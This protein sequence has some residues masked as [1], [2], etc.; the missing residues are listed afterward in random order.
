MKTLVIWWT[1]GMAISVRS[2]MGRQYVLKVD[3][4]ELVVTHHWI[5][6]SKG[7]AIENLHLKEKPLVVCRSLG[8]HQLYHLLHEMF[9][10]NKIY[11]N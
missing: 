9:Q 11:S 3:Q 4:R 10:S 7:K 6:V 1:V 8:E 5:L 2:S